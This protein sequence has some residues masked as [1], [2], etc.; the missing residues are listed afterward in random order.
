MTSAAPTAP[1]DA[2]CR[3]Y[4]G[5]R[6]EP[7]ADAQRLIDEGFRFFLSGKVEN[8][9]ESFRLALQFEPD[10]ADLHH[11]LAAALAAGNR[12]DEAVRHFRRSLELRPNSADT[13]RNYALAL[14]KCG[15]PEESEAAYRRSIELNPACHLARCELGALLRLRRRAEEA[16]VELRESLRLRPDYAESARQLGMTLLDLKR[17]AEAK[18][19]LEAAIALHS[20][21]A[22]LHACLGNVFEQEGKSEAAEKAYRK[23]LELHP[24]SVDVLND[25]G[26]VLAAQNR[27]DEAVACYERALAIRPQ[28]HWVLN[29]LGN[30]LRARGDFERSIASFREAVR[31]RPAYAEAYNNLGITLMHKGMPQAAIEEYERAMYCMP[32][33]PAPHLNRSLAQLTLGDFQ[34]GLVEYEWRWKGPLA[35]GPKY[36]KP[37]WHGEPM[38]GRTVLLHA[39]QGLGDTLQFIRYAK[40][41]K[42]RG[43]RV[44][45]QVQKPLLPLLSRCLWIDRLTPAKEAVPEPY[46]AHASLLSLPGIFGTTME[47]IPTEVPYLSADPALVDRWRERLADVKGLK[48]GIA[49]QGNPQYRGD[50]QR[51]IAL[52]QFAGL[53]KIPGVTLVSLQKGHGAEQAAALKD[54]VPVLDLGSFDDEAGAFMDTAAIMKNL[55]LVICSDSAIVHLAGALGV[56]V[57]LALP[58]NPDWR[59]F[60]DREDSPWYPTMRLFRQPVVDDWTYV[61]NRLTEELR[62]LADRRGPRMRPKAT[63]K[64]ECDR[65]HQ[66]VEKLAKDG[67]HEQCIP[68][69]RRMLEIEPDSAI[70]HQNLGVLL[71]GSRQWNDGER[72]LKRAVELSPENADAHANLGLVYQHGGRFEEAAE[73]LRT[74]AR[75]GGGT[76][77]VHN[78]LGSALVE[79]NRAAEGVAAYRRALELEP[80]MAEAHVNLA[81]TLLSLGEYDEGWLE[82]E[83]RWKL[84]HAKHPKIGRPRWT[85][86]SLAGKSILLNAELRDEDTLQFIRYAPK[87]KERGARVVVRAPARLMRWLAACEGVEGVVAAGAAAPKVDVHAS[88]LSLPWLFKT[89]LSSVPAPQRIAAATGVGARRARADG[90][91]LRIG[92]IDGGLAAGAEPLD[93]GALAAELRRRGFDPVIVAGAVDEAGGA[94][95]EPRASLAGGRPSR[96]YLDLAA[97]IS[98][99]DLVVAPDS[100]AVHVAG[101]LG[102]PTLAVLES[103]NHWRWMTVRTDSPWYPQVRLLRPTFES[104]HDRHQQ[105]VQEVM[106]HV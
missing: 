72:H 39:E 84:K 34:K 25:L 48:V 47:S 20:Q 7:A 78:N 82:L 58:F 35:N 98:H 26:V 40:F 30:A 83:W 9:A 19:A 71:A 53:A 66:E 54:E 101:G 6:S 11:N 104:Q 38:D 28:L 37:R 95:A 68:L 13:L 63:R 102:V 29:N 14:S 100:P 70:A 17:Y 46:K 18:E 80:D 61:F 4:A 43:A 106:R 79:L 90:R 99:C 23:S 74:A 41:V 67:R 97:E 50:R 57:W 65:L 32:D 45:A 42:Q 24:D 33:Y 87:L 60:R 91:P 93:T 103:S 21:S 64:R 22:E 2:A 16:V 3:S 89:S 73:S 94:E 76:A 59:W 96:D 88:L 12:L 36:S 44:V 105:V 55:D 85:G 52:A 86:E 5:G 62:G 49:W 15:R 69:Y 77:A 51:S 8:A 56:P 10:S 27:T 81:Q 1:A 75:L 92:L 31:I